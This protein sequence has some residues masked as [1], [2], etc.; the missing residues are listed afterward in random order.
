MPP[1][2]TFLTSIPGHTLWVWCACGHSSGVRVAALLDL[3][4]APETVTQAIKA[5][6]CSRCKARSIV[7]YRIIYEGGSWN[8][9]KGTRNS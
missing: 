2:D 3:A 6:R 1:S 7:D 5:M 4:Q 8:A 9:M